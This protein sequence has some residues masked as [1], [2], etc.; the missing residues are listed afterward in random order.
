[1]MMERLDNF[2]ES[3]YCLILFASGAQYQP[4]WNWLLKAYRSLGRKYRKNLKNLY[5]VHPQT[6]IKMLMTMVLT[7]V[8]PKFQKKLVWVPNLSKLATLVPIKQINIPD[9]I[10]E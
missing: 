4:S 9:A 10:L 6:W 5:I 3:D 8:S 2:V 1:M 7:V